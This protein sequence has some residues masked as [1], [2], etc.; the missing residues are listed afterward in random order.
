MKLKCIIILILLP[1]LSS[2]VSLERTLRITQEIGGDGS[3]KIDTPFGNADMLLSEG[4]LYLWD[5]DV[6]TYETHSRIFVRP[7]LGLLWIMGLRDT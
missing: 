1:I 5:D 3:L 2:C 4:L 7:P 6:S